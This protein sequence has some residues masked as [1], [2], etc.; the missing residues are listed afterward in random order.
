MYFAVAM[1]VQVLCT[2]VFMHALT[3]SKFGH[4]KLSSALS[5]RERQKLFIRVCVCV[6]VKLQKHSQQSR[7]FFLFGTGTSCSLTFR[8]VFKVHVPLEDDVSFYCHV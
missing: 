5:C 8:E 7:C 2:D 3:L 1:H 4:I 6:Y